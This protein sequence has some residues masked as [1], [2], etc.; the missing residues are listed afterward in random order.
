MS[1]GGQSAAPLPTLDIRTKKL[2]ECRGG[3]ETGILMVSEEFPENDRSRTSCFGKIL[4][5]R[6]Q[7]KKGLVSPF[8]SSAKL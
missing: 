3:S 8:I 2:K 5:G 6:D 7:S 4:K 1:E